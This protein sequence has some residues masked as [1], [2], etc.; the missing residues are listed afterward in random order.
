MMRLN[1]EWNYGYLREGY[2]GEAIDPI[3]AIA[4]AIG[5]VAKATQGTVTSIY[6]Y[7]SLRDQ[8]AASER[9]NRLAMR[10][11][12]GQSNAGWETL[13]LLANKQEESKRI[14]ADTARQTSE[15]GEIVKNVLLGLAV[16]GVIGALGY[17]IY[18][19]TK[20]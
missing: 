4:N 20:D 6:T 19:A 15:Q 14:S 2:A 13:L 7:R 16:L 17:G 18:V 3:T 8:S 10:Q 1:P 12:A 11:L 5:D 9:E